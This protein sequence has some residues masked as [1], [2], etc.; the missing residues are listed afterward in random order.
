MKS[1]SAS[2]VRTFVAC[3]IFCGCVTT[4]FAQTAELTGQITDPSG[5]N[6][7]AAGVTVTNT[8]TGTHRNAKSNAVGLY[9]IPLLQPGPYR[10]AVEK[11]GFQQVVRDVRLQVEQVLR[12]DFSLQVGAMNQAVEVA[13]TSPLLESETSSVGQVVQSRQM[14][15]LPL[16]GRDPYALGGLVPGVRSSQGMTGLPVD[17]ITTYCLPSL[18]R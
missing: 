5:A 9:T 11:A 14:T 8:D 13:A 15:E 12:V 6:V 18:P 2:A 4:A 16:L 7:P 17:V 1:T 10:I 3:L